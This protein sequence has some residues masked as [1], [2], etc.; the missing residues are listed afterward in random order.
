MNTMQKV[1]AVI[2]LLWV[3]A[4]FATSASERL[5]TGDWLGV[6]IAAVASA[7]VGTALV[8]VFARGTVIARL[9]KGTVVL[10]LAWAVL[11]LAPGGP[12]RCIPGWQRRISYYPDLRIDTS[13]V[14][15]MSGARAMDAVDSV[16]G[17]HLL[18]HHPELWRDFG[19]CAVACARRSAVSVETIVSVMQRESAALYRKPQ[20]S[21]ELVAAAKAELARRRAKGAYRQPPNRNTDRSQ[22]DLLA[23][24]R[25]EE[26][27]QRLDSV[28]AVA[29]QD[30]KT[31]RRRTS[32]YAAPAD[33]STPDWP[34]RLASAGSGLLAGFAIVIVLGLLRRK[35]KKATE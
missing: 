1:T 30:A 32:V 10:A 27:R 22:A 26:L 13:A 34:A 17:E 9:Q 15:R 23:T 19:W 7:L 8:V 18:A 3:A 35:P 16:I 24:D 5:G 2:V 31:G 6:G 4:L 29:I 33:A 11:A 12:S 25:R 28:M 21:P 14:S 20:H